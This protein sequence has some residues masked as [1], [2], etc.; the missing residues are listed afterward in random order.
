MSTRSNPYERTTDKI[1]DPPKKFHQMLRY[2]G[3]GFILSASIVGSGELIATTVLGAKAGFITFWMVIVSC[4]VKVTLQLEFGKHAIQSGESTFASFNK[5]PGP[6]FGQGHWTT[7]TWL[8]LMS[9]KF[10]QVGG[11]VGGVAIILQMIAP[12]GVVEPEE[13]AWRG[14]YTWALVIAPCVGLLVFRGYYRSIEK[15]SLIMI[16]LFT[17]LTLMSVLVLQS[18]VYAISWGDLASGMTFQL[19]AETVIV[20]AAIGAFGI[21]GVGGD[22]IMTYN[23]WLLEKGYA[24]KTGPRDDSR[25]WERR[26]K[27]WIKV[28]YW[29]ALLSMVVYTVVT[30]AFYILGAAVLHS[31][32]I[33]P[34]DSQ[35]VETLSKLYTDTLGPWARNAF[36]I[37]AFVVLFSTLFAALAG[38]TRLYSDC[39]GHIGLFNFQ[40]D[41]MRHL[42]MA[43]LAFVIP[44]CWALLYIQISDPG[45]MV[46][47]GGVATAVILLIVVFA[48]LNFR[49]QRLPKSLRPSR[50]YDVALMASAALIMAVGIYTLVKLDWGSLFSKNQSGLTKEKVDVAHFFR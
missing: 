11:I 16:G 10:L 28:M 18:T 30:A 35:I 20:I 26:A 43:G 17:I 25:A 21:T 37:G 23:Y 49:F 19:P 15:L 5:L 50:F 22:E 33:V 3:P 24:A 34:E 32:G 42:I 12:I 39:F 6:K 27:G 2:L 48:A 41:K 29:D 40:N 47:I 14:D 45:V 9:L 7:W 31:Q 13:G 1:Q 36:L 4:L 8:V 38:W 46:I 44:I